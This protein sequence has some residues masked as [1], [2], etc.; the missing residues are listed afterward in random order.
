MAPH[1]TLLALA[2]A[3]LLACS[4]D[5]SDQDGDTTGAAESSEGASS[6]VAVDVDMLAACD[7]S[8]LDAVPFSGPAFDPETGALIEPLPAG[9]IVATTVGWPKLDPADVDAVMEASNR[10]ITEQLFTS[11]GMLG[12]SFGLSARCNSARTLTIWRDEDAL[13]AFVF[14]GVHIEMATTKLIH[15]QAWETTHWTGAAA[16][17]PP[18]WD[19]ARQQLAD[20]RH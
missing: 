14:S 18:S 15:T 6:G 1:R 5:G 3:A 20:A 11:D 17:E 8:D 2:T 13:N 16:T 12:G 4:D 10:V 9:H 19:A 7:E